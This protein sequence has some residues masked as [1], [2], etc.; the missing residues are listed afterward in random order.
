[1][2]FETAGDAG[3]AAFA[4]ASDAVR[5]VL[6]AQ[7]A[8]E[9]EPWGEMGPLR[10]RKGLHLGEVERQDGHSFGASLCRCAPPAPPDHPQRP[11]GCG[12]KDRAA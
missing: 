4:Q 8:L 10:V 2:V 12:R 5:G 1:M 7:A 9:R 3:D 6:A 11:P